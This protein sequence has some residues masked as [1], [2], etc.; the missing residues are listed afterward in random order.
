MFYSIIVLLIGAI[1]VLYLYV[2]KKFSFWEENGVSFERPAF[3]VGNLQL[4]NQKIH[5]DLQIANYYKKAK[6]QN[7]HF[8]F[9][10]LYFFLR[11][12]IV[13]TDLKFA[14]SILIKDFNKFPNR[15]TYYNE[16]DD[17]LSAHLFNVEATKWRDLR[18]KLTPAFTSG[19]MKLMF[20]IIVS[21]V[22]KLVNCINRTIELDNEIEIRDIFGRFT[23]D[24]IGNCAFGIECNSLKDPNTPFRL[25]GKKLFDEPK[26]TATHRI[27]I[28]LCHKLAKFFRIRGHYKDVTDFFYNVVRETVEYRLKNNIH[29]NDFMDLLIQLKSDESINE[30]DENKT[31]KLTL[32]EIAAQAFVFFMAGFE[33]TS[34]ALSYA[35]YELAQEEN[36]KI[37][38]KAR[39]EI[40]R[41]L[42]KHDGHLSYES[43]ADMQYLDQI[44]N[45][46][47]RKYPPVSSLVR[48]AN[49]DYQ[50]DDLPFK[51]PKHCMVM[52][53]VYGI[54]H[55]PEYYNDP[56]K[57]IPERFSPGK[58]EKR[59]ACSFIPFGDGPRNCIG[60][61]F[62]ILQA[63]IA[64]ALLLKNFK[65][66]TCERTDAMPL[67]FSLK[68]M[69]LSPKNEI[70][71]KINR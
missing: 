41:V 18:S 37:Q 19:K 71:L 53:S 55:D 59:P 20:P 44:L 34:M 30:N 8:P 65:F 51:I 45:E 13:V 2:K 49:E 66:S 32:T 70:W 25:M 50:Y 17:P 16:K 68:K 56:E 69:F 29:R 12:V 63:K 48:F 21:V 14:R 47:L 24:V 23:T 43:L 11:P 5:F 1:S 10:G 39:N 4:R 57:F 67:E 35:F 7:N 36:L 61:R 31:D 27:V 46:S 38:E 40:E 3:L 54:H 9:Y 52:I 64:L 58:V 6:Q 60:L 22:E 62:G 42:E 15:G 33:T 28:K 26:L